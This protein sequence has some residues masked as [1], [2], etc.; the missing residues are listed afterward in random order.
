MLQFPRLDRPSS[1]QQRA[2]GS[3]DIHMAAHVRPVSQFHNWTS[4]SGL[5]ASLQPWTTSSW[6]SYTCKF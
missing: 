4:T 3:Q 1:L 5:P 2:V 6:V